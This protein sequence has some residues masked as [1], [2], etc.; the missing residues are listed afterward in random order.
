MTN[1]HM[2]RCPISLIIRKML[3]ETTKR[4]DYIRRKD[5]HIL[6]LQPLGGCRATGTLLH[7]LQDKYI[8]A[9]FGGQ[10]GIF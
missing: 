4:Y 6:T 1:K 7:C 5:H 8:G 2:K 9:L 3:I 10:F